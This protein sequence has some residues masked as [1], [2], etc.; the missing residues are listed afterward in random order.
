MRHAKLHKPGWR[1]LVCC[2]ALG[3]AKLTLAGG[4]VGA[5]IGGATELT[6]MM[7]HF[8]LLTSV[9]QQSAMVTQNITAHITRVQQYM[10]MLQNLAQLPAH[11]LEQIMAPWR[12]QLQMFMQLADSVEALLE[13]A[14]Q[15]R[16]LFK[17]SLSEIAQLNLTPEQWLTAHSNLAKSRDG[18]YQHQ[19]RQDL[20]A[21]DTLAHRARSVHTLSSQIPGITSTIQGLQLLNQQAS[22]LAAEMLELRALMQ[23]QLAMQSKDRQEQ[24]WG[25]RIHFDLIRARQA[26]A[27]QLDTHERQLIHNGP[28]HV[29][30]EQ[31]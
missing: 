27:R 16:A 12:H 24:E 22:I 13:A 28:F 10:A 30:Q 3:S 1:T 15:T 20:A 18:L 4:G 25:D 19:W 21:L 6:Q 17:R 8:E 14:H 23:R 2:I 7:N 5:T 11:A 26:Q 29:L 31:P 9:S